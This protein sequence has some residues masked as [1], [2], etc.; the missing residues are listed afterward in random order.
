MYERY[1]GL[2]EQQNYSVYY[3]G[4]MEG[5]EDL[6]RNLIC[7]KNGI[8][9]IECNVNTGLKEIRENAIT[10]LYGTTVEYWIDLKI[11]SASNNNQIVMEFDDKI[12]YLSDFIKNYESGLIKAVLYTYNIIHQG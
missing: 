6:G 3:H 9:R 1:I 7:I 8:V 5:Y 12:T 4:I 10:Q 11:K 2:Y